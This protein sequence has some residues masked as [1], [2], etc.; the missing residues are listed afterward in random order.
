M[1]YLTLLIILIPAFLF[2]Q[3][4][5]IKKGV[6]EDLNQSKLIILKHEQIEVKVT[7]DDKKE[8]KY[9][10]LRQNNHNKVSKESN[11]KL[12]GASSEYPFEYDLA[13]KSEYKP[14]IDS[15]CKYIL[16]SSVYNNENISTQPNEGE[17]IV[18]EYFI[19][20][21]EN[22]IAYKVFELDEMKV[23]DSKLIIKKLS[24]AV[25]KKFPDAY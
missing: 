19:R 20:D 13:Y 7:S 16:D 6:P 12:L 8:E 21:I 4:T 10:L 1:K 18:Y 15:K 2:S 23:Y 22:N 9:L 14:L 24:K 17:L 25:K 5:T 3:E 11:A